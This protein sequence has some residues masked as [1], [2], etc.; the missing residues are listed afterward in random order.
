MREFFHH[1]LRQMGAPPTTV[2]ETNAQ[3]PAEL[4]KD[5]E[6]GKENSANLPPSV[7]L[8]VRKAQRLAAARIYQLCRSLRIPKAVV[9][10][11]RRFYSRDAFHLTVV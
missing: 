6:E 8:F 7:A 1:P 5:V 11:V 2:F 10:Q 9:N 4:F 3:A